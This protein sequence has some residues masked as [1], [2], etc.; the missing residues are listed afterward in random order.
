MSSPVDPDAWRRVADCA[1]DPLWLLDRQLRVLVLNAAAERAAGLTAAEVTGRDIRDACPDLSGS[2]REQAVLRVLASSVGEVLRLRQPGHE[3]WLDIDIQPDPL[4][5]VIAVRDTGRVAAL[6]HAMRLESAVLDAVSEGIY[7]IDA[8]NKI[9]FMNASAER[10]LG[11]TA[12][13]LAGVDAHEAFHHTR[14]DG[15]PY[16]VEDCPLLATLRDGQPRVCTDLLWRADRTAMSVEY[17]TAPIVEDGSITGAVVSFLDLSDR[18][19]ADEARLA[20]ET[21]TGALHELQ[22][23]L[24]PPPPQ[25]TDPCLGIHYLP[26]DAAAAGGDLYDWQELPNDGMH[27]VVVDV[28]GKGLVAARDALAVTHALRLLT[29]AD[30]P[31]DQ[32]VKQASWLLADAYPDLAATAIVARYDRARHRLRFVSAGHPPPL[33]IS[34]HGTTRYLEASGRPLGWPDAGTDDVID[35]EVPPGARVVFYTDGLIEAR[36]DIVEG[37][38]ALADLA[39][40]VRDLEA[41]AAARHLVVETLTAAVRRDDCLALVLDRPT[42]T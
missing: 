32:V 11:Y 16:P 41:D 35:V 14:A 17:R 8:H 38:Q 37:M 31:L 12:A 24:Q 26:A 15:A 3:A 18:L 6:E 13:A 42:G 28:V 19:A 33:F 9:T 4:G 34:E 10:A 22:Q 5:V 7:G 20:A 36:R 1:S 40:Q 39:L 2:E 29:L 30:T 27:L 25:T 21:A 23:V